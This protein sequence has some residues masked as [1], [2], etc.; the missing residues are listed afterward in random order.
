V[1]SKI[2]TFAEIRYR[3]MVIRDSVD[4]GGAVGENERMLLN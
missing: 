2:V 1:E 4:C 3:R